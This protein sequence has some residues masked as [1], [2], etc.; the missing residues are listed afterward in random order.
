[1]TDIFSKA[2]AAGPT[3][4][5]AAPKAATPAPSNPAP[6]AQ[7]APSSPAPAQAAQAAP[8]QAAAQPAAAKAQGGG[9]HDHVIQQLM[10]M[11]YERSQVEKALRAAFFN[12]ERAVEYLIM[13]IPA[14]LQQAAN[15]AAPQSPKA[16]SIGAALGVGNASAADVGDIGDVGDEVFD[17]EDAQMDEG[18]GPLDFLRTNPEFNAMKLAVQQNPQVLGRIMEVLYQTNPQLVQLISQNQEEFSRLLEEPVD[19][20][21]LARSQL[22]QRMG[23]GAGAGAGAGGEGAP[24]TIQVTAEEKA[25]IE[26]LEA[27][28]FPRQKVIEAYFACDKN[29]EMA[30]NYLLENAFADE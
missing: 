15:A 19:Q 12:A 26:R 22:A 18:D 13:G 11:G 29:E 2:K 5:A 30:A 17:D 8:A 28:G 24:G 21:S 7:A 3:P 1:M 10:E 6:A 4:V 25:A 23:A 16:G 9:E 27:L 14:H 20:E